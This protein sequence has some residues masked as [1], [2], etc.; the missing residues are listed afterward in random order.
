MNFLTEEEGDE[1]V[2]AAY[3]RTTPGSS[4][5]RRGGIPRTRS[6]RTRTSHRGRRAG[7]NPHPQTAG[8]LGPDG[9]KVPTAG[10]G[11]AAPRAAD[12]PSAVGPD[13]LQRQLDRREHGDHLVELDDLQ[14]PVDRPP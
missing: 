9:A 13:V 4:R 10:G 11:Q 8:A 5:P 7:R 12:P 2:R 6:G 14:D 1:R 3:G